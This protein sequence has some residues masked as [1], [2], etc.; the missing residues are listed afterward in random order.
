MK[1]KL[2][3]HALWLAGWVAVAA[4]AIRAAPADAVS[5]PDLLK[6]AYRK[7]VDAELLRAENRPAEAT[8]AYRQA[9]DLFGRLQTDYPGWQRQAVSLRIGECNRAIAAMESV[10]LDKAGAEAFST[11]NEEAR[12]SKLIEELRSFRATLQPGPGLSASGARDEGDAER[13]RAKSDLDEALRDNQ[14][15]LRRIDK[16]EARLARFPR[17]SASKTNAPYRAVTGAVWNEVRRL[18]QDGDSAAAVALVQESEKALP[19]DPNLITLHGIVACRVGRFDEAVRVLQ[20][21]STR[22]S[23]N[24]TALVTL[25]SAYLAMGRL[26]DARVAMEQAV[27]AN[28]ASPEAHFNLAQI[29]LNIRPADLAGAQSHYQKALDLG[30][31]PDAEF[32]SSLH[33]ATLISR[34]RKKK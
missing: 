24:T 29:L 18:L 11:T 21:L 25:G 31:S 4:P 20:P 6:E 17:E 22:S 2:G 14:E 34:M 8:Q 30:M 10:A 1:R 7:T 33:T 26:G 5:G 12:L 23:S 15:L 27:K 16:Q 32:E 9:L 19:N 13:R 28:P 3:I